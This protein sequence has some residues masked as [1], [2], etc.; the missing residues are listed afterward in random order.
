MMIEALNPMEHVMKTQTQRMDDGSTCLS[1]TPACETAAVRLLYAIEKAHPFQVLPD[2]SG[3]DGNQL[4]ANWF[5]LS[6]LNQRALR[7]G[8]A[9]LMNH[10]IIPTSFPTFLSCSKPRKYRILKALDVA[11]GEDSVGPKMRHIGHN[12]E[13][14]SWE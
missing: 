1:T 14:R 6:T 4:P 9:L 7:F 12:A 5:S 13:M 2:H 10:G 11:D 3:K 8:S